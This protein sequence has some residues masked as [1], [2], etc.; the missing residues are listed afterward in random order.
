MKG[1]MVQ[2]A[3]RQGPHLPKI[4]KERGVLGSGP[5]G[6]RFPR[7]MYYLYVGNRREKTVRRRLERAQAKRGYPIR[8][9]SEHPG[10]LAVEADVP[11]SI[12]SLIFRGCGVRRVCGDVRRYQYGR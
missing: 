2:R 7:C 3:F 10:Y 8:V 6:A 5:A 12:L 1:G 11:E 9:V 4:S